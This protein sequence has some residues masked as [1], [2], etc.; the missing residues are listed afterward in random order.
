M[1]SMQCCYAVAATDDDNGSRARTR[2]RGGWVRKKRCDRGGSGGGKV[3]WLLSEGVDVV[4][5]MVT[6]LP[7][8][9]KSWERARGRRRLDGLGQMGVTEQVTAEGKEMASCWQWQ[10]RSAFFGLLEAS[11]PEPKQPDTTWHLA[12]DHTHARAEVLS[13]SQTGLNL[14]NKMKKGPMRGGRGRQLLVEYPMVLLMLLLCLESR[15][16]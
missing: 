5:G 1:Q 7:G 13:I 10:K 11:G 2:A 4:M 8:L 12:L 3:T 15:L 16:E 14:G 9:M 6:R